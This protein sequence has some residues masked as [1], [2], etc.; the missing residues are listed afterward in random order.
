M[1]ATD[2]PADAIPCTTDGCETIKYFAGRCNVCQRE[3]EAAN[4]AAMTDP[5]AGMTWTEECMAKQKEDRRRS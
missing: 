1:S 3:W 4:P 5:Y 2:R